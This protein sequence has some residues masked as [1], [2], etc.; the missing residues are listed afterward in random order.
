MFDVV[1]APASLIC[2]AS[3]HRV[4]AGLIGAVPASLSA[5]EPA[6]ESPRSVDSPARHLPQQLRPVSAAAAIHTTIRHGLEPDVREPT[7]HQHLPQGCSTARGCGC[8]SLAAAAQTAM[9]IPLTAL[10]PGTA[11]FRA[12]SATLARADQVAQ[13]NPST[14]TRQLG[15]LSVLACLTIYTC[16]WSHPCSC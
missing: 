13:P 15:L 16:V 5:H 7:C 6:D 9:T 2:G 4:G 3:P 1:L 8:C 12:P 14:L 10:G 11:S